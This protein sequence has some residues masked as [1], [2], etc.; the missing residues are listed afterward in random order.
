MPSANPLL[1]Q[2]T[3]AVP[4]ILLLV[5]G[6]VRQ[7]ENLRTYFDILLMVLPAVIL[8]PSVARL[9]P[10]NASY[11]TYVYMVL[12]FIIFV[13]P[14]AIVIWSLGYSL[15]DFGITKDKVELSILLGLGALA[16]TS[17]FVALIVPFSPPPFRFSHIFT[18]SLPMFLDAFREELYF[19]G[20]LFFFVYKNS[21]DLALSYMVSIATFLLWHQ[22]QPISLVIAFVQGTLMCYI[23]YKSENIT[24][25]WASRGVDKTLSILVARVI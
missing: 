1:M 24:G 13:V 9:V 8:Y 3:L 5:Y 14:A 16:I 11:A 18:M 6:Y 22:W 10:N 12:N 7:R 4:I 21:K 19:R 15:R 2:A 23:L 25:A 20:I 17:I